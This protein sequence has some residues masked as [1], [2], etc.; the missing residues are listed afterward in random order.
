M[1]RG[2]RP[3][4]LLDAEAQENLVRFQDEVRDGWARVLQRWEHRL[5]RKTISLP[6][7]Y[8]SNRVAVVLDFMV[9]KGRD[10]FC[11][12]ITAAR[13]AELWAVD[14]NCFSGGLVENDHF[15]HLRRVGED[16][17]LDVLVPVVTLADAEEKVIPSLVRLYR[18]NDEVEQ[19]RMG[20]YWS[21]LKHAY[22]SVPI[23]AYRELGVA[24]GGVPE[25]PYYFVP[26]MVKGTTEVVEYVTNSK[27]DVIWNRRGLNSEEL[28]TA[29]CRIRLRDDY[30]I[31]RAEV[32]GNAGVKLADVLIGPFDL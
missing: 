31:V 22:K 14:G 26:H 15:F 30:P 11:G 13:D 32:G 20:F 18:V 27:G 10:R 12:M 17:E 19:E 29:Q 7:D 16:D 6:E 2:D 28:K 3:V 8:L 23:V 24:V 25:P 1:L 21:L 9:G 5:T 4:Y